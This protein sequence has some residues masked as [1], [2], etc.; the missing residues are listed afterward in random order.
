[1]NGEKR[2]GFVR[3]S[4]LIFVLRFKKKLSLSFLGVVPVSPTLGASIMAY[5]LPSPLLI[6]GSGIGFAFK[7]PLG[8]SY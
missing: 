5:K 8:G 1:M 7:A 6:S 4:I 3:S 2:V